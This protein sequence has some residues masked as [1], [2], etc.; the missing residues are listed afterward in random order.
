MRDARQ[1][2]EFVEE[3]IGHVFRRPLMYG[4]TAEAVDLILHHDHELWSVIHGREDEFREV[5]AAIHLAEGCGSASF[6]HHFRTGH[7]AASEDEVACHVVSLWRKIGERLGL[8]TAWGCKGDA[9][10]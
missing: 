1:I 6:A 10:P 9:W 4:G 8:P 5:S 3:R 7:P 2:T